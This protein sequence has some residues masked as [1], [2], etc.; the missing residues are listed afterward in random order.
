MAKWN[1]LPHEVVLQIAECLKFYTYKQ[2][3]MFA[4]KK[5]YEAYL[6]LDYDIV[7]ADLKNTPKKLDGVLNSPFLPGHWTKILLVGN[8]TAPGDL[9]QVKRARDPLYNLM[10]R[11]PTA[12]TVG[13]HL[14]KH[15][16]AKDWLYFTGA[17]LDNT[18]WK[19]TSL[20][21]PL[22]N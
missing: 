17:L 16:D 4:N 7:Y 11:C 12:E 1:D 20:P 22:E 18:T 3:W 14:S 6:S 19:L 13:F 2:Q 9:K 15:I 5:L 10:K 8:F 21:V